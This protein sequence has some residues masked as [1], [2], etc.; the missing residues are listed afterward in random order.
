[1]ECLR[2]LLDENQATL[3]YNVLIGE[4]FGLRKVFA[5]T[6]LKIQI[7]IKLKDQSN[8]GKDLYLVQ[9]GRSGLGQTSH[10]A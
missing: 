6:Y 4:I 7:N 2:I 3:R 9:N 5:K 8:P 10:L 1:M